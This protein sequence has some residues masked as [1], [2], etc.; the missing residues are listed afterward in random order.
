VPPVCLPEAFF[1]LAMNIPDLFR[2]P[3]L[4]QSAAGL[5]A[6]I[7]IGLILLGL[8]KTVL[9]VVNGNPEEITTRAITVNGVLRN[10]EIQVTEAE[11]INL[12]PQALL[13]G[14]EKILLNLSR[15]IQ[16]TADGNTQT[17]QSAERRPENILL[18]LG[19][20]LYPKD[21]VFVDGKTIRADYLLSL[22]EPHEIVLLRGTPITVKTEDGSFEF[23][24]AEDTLGE[25]FEVQGVEIFEADQLSKPL[26]TTLE[27]S[28]MEVELIRA[29]PLY[30]L[31]GGEVV[32]IRSTENTIG[33]A[34]TQGG[35][36]LQGLDYTIPEEDQPIPDNDQIKLIRVREEIL[37][38]QEQIQFTSE[39]QPANDLSLDELQ[40]M[41][42]GEFGIEGQRI[43]ITYEDDVEISR[44]LEKEWVIRDPNPRVIGYGTQINI[45]T[46][47]TADGQITYWR[48][49]TA[50][51]TSYNENCPGCSNT[52]SS[53]AYL[54]KGV[55]AV[56]LEWYRY[57]KGL[58]VYIP[59]YGFA[60][61]EDVGGG[62]PW[63]A[64]WVDLGYRSENYVP[65]SENVTVY[66]LA[67]A[68]PPENIMY[69]L[70]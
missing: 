34:L 46:A 27:G 28:P 62:V 49:I 55:I 19:L 37:L 41:S 66:F 36:P 40:I 1:I 8:N 4:Q 64:N 50:Y 67:P 54:K 43:R 61:I 31:V 24:S 39:Y 12:K 48:K 2:K 60:T 11:Q 35:I 22:G 5:A 59:G 32:T 45:E 52:T 9:L 26:T 20:T 65:W 23:I 15:E 63:S 30:V 51:A 13:W 18:E 17:V 57:M 38:K 70:Y 44:E 29:R 53:G 25:A 42:G 3:L 14:G 10:Q 68:P 69:V 6:L 33:A 56:R 47:N 21:R 58:R 7:G 16:I